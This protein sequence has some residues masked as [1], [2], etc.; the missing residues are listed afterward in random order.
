M[1]LNL[2][3]HRPSMRRADDA[4][5]APVA[6]SSMQ[7]E[8]L[9]IRRER[10]LYLR[11]IRLGEENDLEPFLAE[12]LALVVEITGARQGYLELV[13]DG[14]ASE[15]RWWIGHGFSTSEIDGVRALLS[16]GII[17]EAHASRQTILTG[18]AALDPRHAFG[19]KLVADIVEHRRG[20]LDTSQLYGRDRGKQRRSQDGGEQSGS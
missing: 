4:M 17:A 3:L 18:A 5:V 6:T 11:L 15:R 19:R 1:N 12:A 2:L 14:G 13:D 16:R 20:V 8:L 10:D 9:R 7:D